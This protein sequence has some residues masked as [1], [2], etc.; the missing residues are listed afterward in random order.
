MYSNSVTARCLYYVCGNITFILGLFITLFWKPLFYSSFNSDLRLT[1]GSQ[2]H[3][4]WTENTVPIYT[5]IY[6]FNWT[7]PE[8]TL[9]KS[10][11]ANFTEMGPYIF[12][13]TMKKSD[14]VWNKNDTVT[15]NL[16]RIWDF[17]PEMSNGNLSDSVTN[18][19]AVAISLGHRVKEF[20]S[21]GKLI[22]N[23]A[24]RLIERQVYITK[25]VEELLFEGYRD[26]LLSVI[27][28]FKKLGIN[29]GSIPGRF[30]WYFNKNATADDRPIFNI[31][32]GT[33]DL[34]LL[35]EVH[36]WNYKT[37]CGVYSAQCDR[38][39][40]SLGDLW[41][42][43]A[44]EK[45]TA[46]VFVPDFCGAID[47]TKQGPRTLHGIETVRFVSTEKTFD[48]GV[49]NPKN[50]CYSKNTTVSI[51]YGVRD[52]SECVHGPIYASFPHFYSA[53]HTYRLDINGMNPV[54]AKHQFSITLHKELGMLMEIL[55]RLQINV[56]VEPYPG[57]GFF[58]DLPEIMVPT[59][60]F[61][62]YIEFPKDLEDQL[63]L[64]LNYAPIL[65]SLIGYVLIIAGVILIIV[66][67]YCTKYYRES[68]SFDELIFFDVLKR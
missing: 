61:E 42:K 46:S 28:I 43:N 53:D 2:N 30:G 36:S 31:H 47:L 56:K 38:V 29:T 10:E 41:P 9:S 12:R 45:Q 40:G 14:T 39:R 25:S 16:D 23:Q 66:G 4:V 19:N 15:F 68:E 50:S 27:D 63:T 58:S 54:A 65:I 37:E 22:M 26:Q 5:K 55:G 67:Y 20:N 21:V 13:Y 51:P 57:F 34:N 24:L 49:K 1:S 3:K 60:W 64:L 6:M 35:G 11:K 18:I 59:F 17:V 62:Q 52:L 44:A 7:N 32:T 48:N 8:Q 33:D